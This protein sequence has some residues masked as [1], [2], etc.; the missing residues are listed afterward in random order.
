MEQKKS[1]MRNYLLSLCVAVA[2]GLAL[3]GQVL[4]ACYGL[5]AKTVSVPSGYKLIPLKG[6][7]A[8]SCEAAKNPNIRRSQSEIWSAACVEG[9]GVMMDANKDGIF[10]CIIKDD[11]GPEN[12]YLKNKKIL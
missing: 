1:V 4:A 9:G 8:V 11:Q 5:T 2:F 7:K 12:K 3:P 6:F 10:I